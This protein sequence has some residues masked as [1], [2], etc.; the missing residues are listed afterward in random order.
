MEL[1][2]DEEKMNWLIDL[3]LFQSV[4]CNSTPRFLKQIQIGF[5]RSQILV[6]QV[7]SQLSAILILR[8]LVRL[9]QSQNKSRCF[10]GT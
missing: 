6:H 3:L 4:V 5:S 10:T 7:L 9:R 2:A 8:R 1:F